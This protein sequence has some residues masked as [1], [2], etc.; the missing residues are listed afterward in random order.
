MGNPQPSPKDH[1]LMIHGCS[2]QTRCWW[3]EIVLFLLLVFFFRL[4]SRDRLRRKRMA[5]NTNWFVRAS[6][7]WFLSKH[8]TTISCLI[9]KTGFQLNV[10]WV[11]ALT[12]SAQ[13]TRVDFRCRIISDVFV[14]LCFCTGHDSVTKILD[15]LVLD[16]NV[17]S[18]VYFQ[19]RMPACRVWHM[20]NRLFK[21][22]NQY[23]Q[24]IVVDCCAWL[25]SLLVGH[26]VC[27]GSAYN[28]TW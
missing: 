14:R 1:T 4:F 15:S 24:S 11:D 5:P 26:A 23:T 17:T 20:N 18:T 10:I 6:I 21:A 12:I 19:C 13:M 28:T 8:A 3:A 9:H 16:L 27:C 2:S 25:S 22:F 7:S